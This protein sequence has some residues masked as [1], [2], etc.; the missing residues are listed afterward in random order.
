MSSEQNSILQGSKEQ[1]FPHG[2][3][4]YIKTTKLTVHHNHKKAANTAQLRKQFVT[5]F[6][7]LSNNIKIQ[8]I[9]NFFIYNS[10]TELKCQEFINRN[11]MYFCITLQV[12][13]H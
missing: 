13:I 11:I 9:D 1:M 2:R 3:Q 5:L 10:D 6:S 8:A 12:W 4:L 7:C